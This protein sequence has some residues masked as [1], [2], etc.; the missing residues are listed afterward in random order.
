MKCEHSDPR[1]LEGGAKWCRLCGALYTDPPKIM[2]TIGFSGWAHPINDHTQ[3]TILNIARETLAARGAPTAIL[4]RDHKQELPIPPLVYGEAGA[5]E[6]LRLWEKPD[7]LIV[8]HRVGAWD[9]P[10]TWG[11]ALGD[12]VRNVSRAYVEK[13]NL[14]IEDDEGN[15]EVVTQEHIE[16]RIVTY[17]NAEMEEATAV[18]EEVKFDA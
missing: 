14:V 11:I 15:Q 7:G 5:R 10:I 6:I 18:P 13:G 17:F 16:E 4:E 8:Q 12:I 1:P 2:K 9:D 3:P